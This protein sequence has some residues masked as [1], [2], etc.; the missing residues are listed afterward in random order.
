MDLQKSFDLVFFH[1][2]TL[3]EQLDLED[4]KN[5]GKSQKGHVSLKDRA[6]EVKSGIFVKRHSSLA[7]KRN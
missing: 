5:T 7:A 3:S 6:I 4:S 2:N 1:L